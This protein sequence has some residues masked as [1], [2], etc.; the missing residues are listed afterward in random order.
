MSSVRLVPLLLV[1]LLSV[2]VDAAETLS[3]KFREGEK[4]GYR[5]SQNITT[6]GEVQGNKF[7]SLV[8][9][10]LLINTQ[11]KS[12]NADGSAKAEQTIDRVQMKMEFPN[13]QAEGGKSTVEIDS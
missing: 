12:V 9:Q 3:M 5:I 1:G 8:A 2:S 13:P 11:V 10:K 4:Y 7:E 6:T